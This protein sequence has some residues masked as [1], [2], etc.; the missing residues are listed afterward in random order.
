LSYV[1]NFAPY[2][3]GKGWWRTW[4]RIWRDKLSG[5][6]KLAGGTLA[7]TAAGELV[8][9]WA[10]WVDNPQAAARVLPALYADFVREWQEVIDERLRQPVPAD[11]ANKPGETVRDLFAEAELWKV[12]LVEPVATFDQFQEVARSYQRYFKD[13]QQRRPNIGNESGID[14]VVEYLKPEAI[15]PTYE[16]YANYLRLRSNLFKRALNDGDDAPGLEVRLPIADLR[17]HAYVVASTG[18]GK[19]ELLKILAHQIAGTGA[20]VLVIDPHGPLAEAVGQFTEFADT[21]HDRL[22]YLDVADSLGR[23]CVNPFDGLAESTVR[24][25]AGELASALQELLEDRKNAAPGSTI[26]MRLMIK[27][28]VR[29]LLRNSSSDLRELYRF[30]V[31]EDNGDLIDLGKRSEN[32]MLASYFAVDFVAKERGATKTAVRARL[33]EILDGDRMHL[34]CGPATVDIEKCLDAGKVVVLNLGGVDAGTAEAVGRFM[35]ARLFSMAKRRGAERAGARRPV[36][37]I[38]DEAHLYLSESAG[39]ILAQARKFGVHLIAAQQRVD[40]GSDPEVQK[41]LMTQSAVKLLGVTSQDAGTRRAFANVLDIEPEALKRMRRLQFAVAIDG[42]EPAFF[43]PRSDLVDGGKMTAE[44]WVRM[45]DEQRARY[46]RKPGEVR[47]KPAPEVKGEEGQ[48]K[49]RLFPD[50]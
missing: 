19:T 39:D 37:A 48:S 49:K 4:V 8:L 33:Q 13:W 25:E 16:S 26:N 28:C 2:E 6:H 11:L 18:G 40:Q 24:D 5:A 23:P 27:N 42:Q 45:L 34:F 10:A 21:W 29:V 35:M 43:W 30:M 1:E 36:F 31:D 32:E 3:M 14:N 20:G 46:Y 15:R 47:N 44:Q 9:G 7:A 22:V 41:L 12:R 17:R 50:E 38:A